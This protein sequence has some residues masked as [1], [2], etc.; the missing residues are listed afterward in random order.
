M[1]SQRAQRVAGMVG[2]SFVALT[3]IPFIVVPPPPAAGTAGPDVVAYYRAY[4][5]ILLPA[6]WIGVL[7]FPTGLVLLAALT[8]LF[9]HA[10]RDGA[11]LYLLFISGNLLALSVAVMLGVVGQLLPLS[12][13]GPLEPG[14]AKVFS[15]LLGLGFAVYFIP[16]TAAWAA[17]G[18]VII[19]TR[20]LPVWLGWWAVL[21]IA[22]SL[23]A[24]LGAFIEAGPLVAGG[25]G[26]LVALLA[27][28]AWLL[29]ASIVLVARPRSL[30]A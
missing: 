26:S 1:L 11:W 2:I 6:G 17:A 22:T 8:A 27:Q 15:D 30:V 5:A 13:N 28:F 10:E 9:R 3:V 20:I 12:V 24:S 25:L 14:L 19:S 4:R 29:A 18:L 23:I 21:L 7:G 16:S